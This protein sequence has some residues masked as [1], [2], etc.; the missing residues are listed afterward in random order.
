M[1]DG[2]FDCTI[3]PVMEAWGFTTQNFRIPSEEELEELLSHVDYKQVNLENSTVTIPEDV[4]LDLGG[5]AKGFTSSRVMDIFRE[6]GV[7]S[8]IISLGGN[9]QAL[10]HKPDGNM[11]RVGIQDPHDLNST[12]AVVEVADQAVITSGG[13]Q[14]YFEDN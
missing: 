11:W 6:N 10:G 7:T 12:F 14:R 2:L 8:G 5:I 3:E 1:T 4:R 9:V 13:Y